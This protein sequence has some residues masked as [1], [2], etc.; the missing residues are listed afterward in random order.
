MIL[1]ASRRTL[2]LTALG[3]ILLAVGAQW[4]FGY[5]I[6]QGS[7]Q[8][9]EALAL[10]LY[11]VAVVLLFA[12]LGRRHALVAGGLAFIVIAWAVHLNARLSAFLEIQAGGDVIVAHRVFLA[13]L[14]VGPALGL[15]VGVVTGLT[16]RFERIRWAPKTPAS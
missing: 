11:A 4:A 13:T 3:L 7:A 1:T 16:A 6:S 15:L 10:L 8:A 9:M 2:T 14:I 5:R 12:P